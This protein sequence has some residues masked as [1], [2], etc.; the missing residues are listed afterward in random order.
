MKFNLPFLPKKEQEIDLFE[1]I[2]LYNHL[3]HTRKNIYRDKDGK[4]FILTKYGFQSVVQNNLHLENEQLVRENERLNEETKKNKSNYK[5]LTE[6]FFE[7]QKQN[8]ELLSQEQQNDE[9]LLKKYEEAL[10]KIERITELNKSLTD[11]IKTKKERIR[12]LIAENKDLLDK[13]FD[14]DKIATLRRTFNIKEDDY[15]NQK[16]E[17]LVKQNKEITKLNQELLEKN[18][19]EKEKKFAYKSGTTPVN[20]EIDCTKVR[21]CKMKIKLQQIEIESLRQ[22]VNVLMEEVSK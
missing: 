17:E 4:E 8:E 3:V 10:K 12:M 13:I 21:E 20:I 14:P 15:V 9:Q 19:K 22:Q 11:K 7:L 2:R 16:Y 1:I 18:K 6:D 5:K